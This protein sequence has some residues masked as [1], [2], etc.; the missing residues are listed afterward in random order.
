MLYHQR[1]ENETAYLY[2][3]LVTYQILRTA[4]AHA[5]AC[6][7]GTDP[8]RAS[9]TIAWQTAGDQLIQAAGSSPAPPS[10]WPAPSAGTCWPVCCP[11]GGCG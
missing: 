5:T 11:P 8:D 1:W 3:L 7:P 9:F 4:M 6:L 2:A 10:T